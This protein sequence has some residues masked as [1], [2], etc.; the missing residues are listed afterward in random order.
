MKRL[1]ILLILSISI[2]AG[3]ILLL[4]DL[5][6]QTGL[7]RM[8]YVPFYIILMISLTIILFRKIKNKGKNEQIIYWIIFHF[9]IFNFIIWSWPQDGRRVNVIGEFYSKFS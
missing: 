2:C 3:E 4:I 1:I 9:L 6:P 5:F 8:L 7:A